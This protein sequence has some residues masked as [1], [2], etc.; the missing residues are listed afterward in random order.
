MSNRPSPRDIAMYP[1][2]LK[3]ELGG[4]NA[5]ERERIAAEY[6]R[7]QEKKRATEERRHQRALNAGKCA[8]CE[9]PVEEWRLRKPRS[10]STCSECER[11]VDARPWR[12]FGTGFERVYP[13]S[14][15][16]SNILRA[17]TVAIWHL[18]HPGWRPR[19]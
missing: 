14:I 12:Q 15:E 1:L 7:R 13:V 11:P 6:H 8:I 16:L 9:S 18:D 17:C 5:A 3:E 4:P 10:L 19:T 2:F